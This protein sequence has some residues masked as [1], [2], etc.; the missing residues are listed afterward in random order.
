MDIDKFVSNL[1][2]IREA[3]PTNSSGDNGFSAS[4]DANGPVAGYDRHLFP[5]DE[6]LL[7]QDFQTPAEPGLAKWEFSPI[8]PVMKVSLGSN[9]GDGPSIDAMVDASKEYVNKMTQGNAKNDIKSPIE[10]ISDIVRK[11]RLQEDAPVNSVGGG[12]IAGTSQAGDD[13]P[14]DL[15]KKKMR[16]WNP[17]FK[18]LARIQRRRK[19]GK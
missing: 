6:N 7:S 11:Y 19:N 8:Y 17:F 15:R 3:A 13:P 18:D 10:N 4:S 14:V 5:G 9:L 2:N 12:A 16:D 1:K